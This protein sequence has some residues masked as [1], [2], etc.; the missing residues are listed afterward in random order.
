[1]RVKCVPCGMHHSC[2]LHSVRVDCRQCP[3]PWAMHILVPKLVRIHVHFDAPMSSV[4]FYH[5]HCLL[6]ASWA[7]F[8]L[9]FAHF[10][11]FISYFFLLFFFLIFFFG[12]WPVQ[13]SAACCHNFSTHCAFRYSFLFFVFF[14]T[15]NAFSSPSNDFNVI[16]SGWFFALAALN[17]FI[18]HGV[19]YLRLVAAA[20]VCW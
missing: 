11:F 1:M 20:T 8:F 19:I 7:D 17:L 18:F 12:L 4:N 16:C 14:L 15:G 6:P 3:Y 13:G 9:R 2:R 5:S 10:L